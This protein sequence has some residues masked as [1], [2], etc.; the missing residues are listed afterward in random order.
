MRSGVLIRRVLP[1]ALAILAV[2][3]LMEHY[4]VL[5][6][7]RRTLA[8]R[9]WTRGSSSSSSS[10]GGSSGDGGGS[11]SGA[12]KDSETVDYGSLAH[13]RFVFWSA[14][15]HISPPADLKDLFSKISSPI[16]KLELNEKSISGHCHLTNSCATNLR[17]LTPELEVDFMPC[18]AKNRFWQAYRSDCEMD[19]ID[20]FFCCHG[21]AACELY[22][23]FNRPMFILVTTRYEL[24]R[25][26]QQQW[27]QF[28]DILVHLARNASGRNIVAANNLFDKRYV[29]YFTGLQ[30]HEVEL[31]P[32]FCGYV[33]T[34]SYNP[35]RAS[36][37]VGPSRID[38][39]ILQLILDAFAR[40]QA[41]S[42]V[43][44]TQ[45][46]E[47]YEYSDLAQHTAMIHVPYQVWISLFLSVCVCV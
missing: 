36:L 27:Q 7:V 34:N 8:L 10:S 45:A 20:A 38:K 13:D 47:H 31:V 1:V 24:G 33:M 14:D 39:G 3:F 41:V 21:V 28:N 37:L 5:F 17:V 4:C 32:S 44:L 30:D 18:E 42:A 11:S 23:P 29:Q 12:Q 2:W 26:Q 25:F 9:S 40:Q 19:D 6:R 16:P 46:Y 22:L 15:A 35:T 43:G